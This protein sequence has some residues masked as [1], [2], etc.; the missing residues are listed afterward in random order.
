M[1]IGRN[2][3]CSC[4]SGKKYK[5]C[6]MAKEQEA[7]RARF[8]TPESTERGDGASNQG[9][10]LAKA[11]SIP[12]KK[13]LDPRIEA[14]DA[15]FEEFEGLDHAGQ[16]ALFTQ[17][18]NDQA[19]MDDE[20]AFGMLEILYEHSIKMGDY[21]QF[22]A[23]LEEL[24]QRLPEVYDHDAHYYCAWRISRALCC[25]RVE[26]LP[27]LAREIAKTAGREIDTFNR[28][29]DQLAYHG[30]LSMLVDAYHIAWPLVKESSNIVSWG[31]DAFSVRAGN[32]V[33]FDALEKGVTVEDVSVL[34]GSLA[35]YHDVDPEKLKHYITHIYARAES[36]WTQ[37]DFDF[38]DKPHSDA[39]G[40]AEDQLYGLS[41]EF[42]GYLR[43]TE[44]VPYTK[45]ELAREQLNRYLLERHAGELEWRPSP[46]D[47]IL[48]RGVKPR[49]KSS[50]R[51][52]VRSGLCPDAETLDRYFG[53]LLNF[54]SPQ[55]YKAAATMELIPAWLR[56]LESL[57]F[58]DAQQR[59]KTL[60]DLQELTNGLLKAWE[61]Y[62]DDPALKDGL[63]RAQG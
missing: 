8:N 10:P 18:L 12:E 15:C 37:G 59:E 31:I 50:V 28:V 16:V 60:L 26:L 27:A 6:C 48:N 38:L 5:K 53:Q 21:D 9:K 19:L 51:S 41:L 43:R 25:G 29:S 2:D 47:E 23:L 30:H 34:K 56:F 32:Y 42:L 39:H 44:G 14:F 22:D 1:K 46:M 52:S 3:P 62:L 35:P 49:K 20:M 17:T 63:V 58:I 13:P 61:G 40:D 24:R 55:H 36:R 33:I 4:G 11:P 54:I 57:G 45:G 7:G